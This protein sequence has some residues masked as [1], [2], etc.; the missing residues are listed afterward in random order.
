MKWGV[1]GRVERAADFES[2]A[3]HRCGFKLRQE[4]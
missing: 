1:C 4:L 2:V 3:L